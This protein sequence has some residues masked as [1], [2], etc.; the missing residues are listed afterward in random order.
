MGRIA[1]ERLNGLWYP[2]GVQLG[3]REIPLIDR[4]LCE[5]THLPA[6][7]SASLANDL[8]DPGINLAG[9]DLYIPW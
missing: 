6:T 5:S 4:I 7:P 3:Q 8:I 2:Q 1:L 9:V